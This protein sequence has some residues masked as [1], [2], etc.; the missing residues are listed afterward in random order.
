MRMIKWIVFLLAIML[1]F[2][3]KITNKKNCYL[4]DPHLFYH[5]ESPVKITQL[6]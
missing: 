5:L 2:M 6:L 3:S 4:T 1:Y